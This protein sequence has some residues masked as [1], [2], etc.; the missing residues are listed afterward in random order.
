[1]KTDVSPLFSLM[2]SFEFTAGS[3][4]SFVSLGEGPLE[5]YHVA[6]FC[7]NVVQ[8]TL[9]IDYS[10]PIKPTRTVTV[11]NIINA[12]GS[13]YGVLFVLQKDNF[14]IH[15]NVMRVGIRTRKAF[16]PYPYI[17]D[18]KN[19]HIFTDANDNM[20]VNLGNTTYND[21]VVLDEA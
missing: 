17:D 7:R 12:R 3:V 19:I 18:K 8:S 13:V 4:N 9:S 6:V 11:Y 10:N 5:E 20:I 2:D 21:Y 14:H 1:M 16:A 15:G